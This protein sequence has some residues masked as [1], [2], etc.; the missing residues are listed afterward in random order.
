GVQ[1][2]RQ[3]IGRVLTSNV[4]TLAQRGGAFSANLRAPLFLQTTMAGG[5]TSVSAVT[6]NTG[7][8]INVIDTNGNTIQAR[9]GQIFRISDRRAYAGNIIPLADFDP[10][11]RKLLDRYPLPTSTAAANN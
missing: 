6:T 11:A 10:V 9:V 3:S 4:P 2:K 1:G 7:T 8:P 5:V